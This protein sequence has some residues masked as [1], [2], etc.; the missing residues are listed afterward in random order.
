MKCTFCSILLSLLTFIA[1]AYSQ[2]YGRRFIIAPNYFVGDFYIDRIAQ[3][4]YFDWSLKVDLKTGAV[5]SL[6]HAL[7]STVTFGNKLHLMF[8]RDTLY[9]IDKD[10]YYALIPQDTIY[11]SYWHF[12]PYFSP[13]DTN[14]MFS[15]FY[16]EPYPTADITNN[17]IFSLKDSSFIPVDSAVWSYSDYMGYGNSPQWSSDTSFV[18]E[19]GDSA[20]AEYFIRSGRIDT[21]VSLHSYKYHNKIVSFAYNTKYNILAYST[22]IGF[23]V[24]DTSPLIYFHYKDSATDY[25]AFS[26]VRDDPNCKESLYGIYTFLNWS[27]N[28]DRLGFISTDPINDVSIVYFY[29]LNTQQSY[30]LTRCIDIGNKHSLQWV[31]EDTLVYL[32][33]AYTSLYGID[34]SNVDA[35]RGIKDKTP[36]SNCSLSCYPNPFNPSTTIEYSLPKESK[37]KL[38]I[39]DILGRKVI[40]LVNKTQI[41]GTHYLTFNASNLSSGI[42]FYRID[43]GKYTLVRKMILLK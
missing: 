41:A 8:N 9:N 7:I 42:Y 14:L 17:F 27:P 6:E 34:V 1:S 13:N 22:D 30:E 26:P 31:N 18:Y 16:P 38:E 23:S 29:S 33:Y 5:D 35:I 36:P 10:T 28:N 11:N 15:I 32:M 25:L 21:L 43:A 3:Q 40:T 2:S 12:Y 4:I 39:Y 24:P 20:L 19:A 37:V